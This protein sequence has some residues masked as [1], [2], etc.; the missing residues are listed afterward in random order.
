M[1][2]IIIYLFLS[3]SILCQINSNNFLN[4]ELDSWDQISGPSDNGHVLFIKKNSQ[5]HL[6]IGTFAGVYRSINNGENWLPIN[7]NL[8]AGRVTSLVINSKD[9]IFVAIYEAG[10]FRSLDNGDS[11]EKINAG[12]DYVIPPYSANYYLAVDMEDNLFV[13]EL[14]CPAVGIPGILRYSEQENN[15]IKINNF[16]TPYF[17][18]INPYNNFIYAVG[19][20]EGEIYCSTNSGLDWEEYRLSENIWVQSITSSSADTLFAVTWGG[21]GYSDGAVFKSADFGVSWE[22]TSL[23]N[24][25]GLS[26]FTHS[27]GDIF[28]GTIGNLYKSSDDGL[29]WSDYELPTG[30]SSINNIEILSSN[31]IFVGTGSGVVKSFNYDNDWI[32]SNN[33][34][35]D[36]GR[37][38]AIAC[39][40]N[41]ELFVGVLGS[42]LF[43]SEDLGL[44]W[45]LINTGFYHPKSAPVYILFS[46]NNDIYAALQF[47]GIYKS[48]DNGLSW[49]KIFNQT[50]NNPVISLNSLGFIYTNHDNAI[51]KS[52]DNGNTWTLLN[53]FDSNVN[54]ITITPNDNILAGT[55]YDGIFRSTDDGITWSKVSTVSTITSFAVNSQKYIFVSSEYRYSAGIYISFDDGENW[56]ALPLPYRVNMMAVHK[57]SNKL[58][59]SVRWGAWGVFVSSDNGQNWN[60]MTDGLRFTPINSFAF[61]SNHYVYIGTDGQ[62]ILRS[63]QKLITALEEDDNLNFAYSLYQNYPNPFNPTTTIK[64]GLAEAA[65]VHL[66]VYNIIGEQVIEIVNQELEAGYHQ[67]T[68]DASHLSSGVYIYQIKAGEFIDT[69][70][71]ILLK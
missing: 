48:V 44:N 19:G 24:I 51:S 9:E 34:L 68:F 46:S 28:V 32:I 66:S 69:K 14:I 33:G 12:L 43:K 22:K 64:F 67:Y 35:N 36:L 59:A 2:N 71:L 54:T 15:W 30:N 52:T 42:G 3:I 50:S 20:L 40:P 55:Y 26:L 1:N 10:V 61:S 53:N 27:N 37:I 11:W 60:E 39:G 5:D 18:F 6:F 65:V 49:V 56:E 4:T 29:T 45:Q 8:I 13:G 58:F 57:E 31:T 47:G 62:G 17:L 7:N 41:D 70:K 63:S 16:I 21:G 25:A 38:N 23:Q